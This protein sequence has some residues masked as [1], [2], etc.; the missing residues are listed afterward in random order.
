MNKTKEYDEQRRGFMKRPS[1]GLAALMFVVLGNCIAADN[2]EVAASVRTVAA[3]PGVVPPGTSLLVQTK[4]TVKARK[5]S[6]GTVYAAS[7]AADILDQNGGVL[8][9]KESS[10]ELIVRSVPYLGPGGVGM[11]LLTLDIDSVTVGDV[12][13]PVETDDK[14]PGAGGIGVAHGPVQWIGGSQEAAS[15]VVTRGDRINVPS[16]T[17]LAFKIQAP[18]RLRGYER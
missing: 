18:I 7:I 11:T 10:I 9:P 15:H 6:R 5:A 3:E 4:D 14:A 1:L 8:I 12:S 13:Y 16:N 2:V 17:L